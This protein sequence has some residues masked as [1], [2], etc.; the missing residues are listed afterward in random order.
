[1]RSGHD[2]VQTWPR[3]RAVV[4][5]NARGGWRTKAAHS[6]AD[7]VKAAE[8]RSVGRV[9]SHNLTPYTPKQLRGQSWDREQT[10]NAT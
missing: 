4:P 9:D 5:V 1:M 3:P 8:R 7:I 6:S 10:T 2:F